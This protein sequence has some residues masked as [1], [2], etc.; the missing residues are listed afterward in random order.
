MG[1]AAVYAVA[2]TSN[3]QAVLGFPDVQTYYVGAKTWRMNQDNVNSRSCLYLKSFLVSLQAPI[4]STLPPISSTVR[5]ASHKTPPPPPPLELLLSRFVES[6]NGTSNYARVSL[7]KQEFLTHNMSDQELFRNASMVSQTEESGRQVPKVAFMFMTKGPLPF[8]LLW[9]KFFKGHEGFYSIY[10]HAHPSFN[11]SEPE[12]S[13]F[14]GRRIPSQP[15]YWGTSS[16]IDAERRLLAN[17]LLDISNQ[18]FVLLSDSCIPLFNFKIVYNYLM[19]SNLSFL[20]SFDDP[21]KA[22]RGRYSP[23]MWPLINI[24]DWRK[25]SQWFEVHRDL[26]MHIVSDTKYYPIFQKHCLMPCYMDE[27]YIP[28][29]AN[30]L[31]SE[32]NSNRSITWV[33]WSR[34][35]PHPAK[36]GW[37]DITDEFLNQIRFG[38]TCPYNENTTSICFLFAR[39]FLPITLE[40]LL[41]VAPLLLGLEP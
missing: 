19:D 14:Y 12:D 23:Q 11:D 41:R 28:T 22:G 38:S 36:F 25:G 39:K 3:Y 5:Q 6:A 29:L 4:Y 37:G 2:A 16:M 15:V 24:T 40:P 32:F 30:M 13:I 8:S 26:A 33:D 18:R 34:G 9:E 1:C 21:R 31:Y 7:K 27:H 20:G 35:G 10:V 17:A